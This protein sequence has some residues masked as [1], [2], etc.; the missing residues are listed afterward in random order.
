[1]RVQSGAGRLLGVSLV[2]LAVVFVVSVVGRVE[3]PDKPKP[4]SPPATASAGPTAE[5]SGTVA[6]EHMVTI[7]P[8]VENPDKCMFVDAEL[9]RQGKYVQ[10]IRAGWGEWVVWENKMGSD[11]KLRFPA[12]KRLFGVLE[13]II[14]SE[15]EPLKLRVRADADTTLGHI[16][17][18]E[19]DVTQPEPVIIVPPPPGP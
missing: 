3:G 18:P 12:T 17:F 13:A 7:M 4:V 11:V 14:Y 1:M 10:E 19:C 2:C 9:A 6:K 16:Y 8:S 15:G 5:P